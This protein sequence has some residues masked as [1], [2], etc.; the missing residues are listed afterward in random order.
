MENIDIDIDITGEKRKI[1]TE[2]I[3]ICVKTIVGI[4]LSLSEPIFSEKEISRILT[5]IATAL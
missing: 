2:E 5:R 3:D 4:S 1:T